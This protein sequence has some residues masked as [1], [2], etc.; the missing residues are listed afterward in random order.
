MKKILITLLA[1]TAILFNSCET[2]F[3]VTAEW[4]DI[5]VV[6]GLIS[7]NDTIHYIKVNKAFLGQGNALA[8]AQEADSSSYLGQIDVWLVEKSNNQELRRFKLDTTVVY[9]KEPG[10]FYAPE[11]VVYKTGFRVPTDYI[12]K[13]ITYHLEINNLITGKVVSSVTPLVHDFNIET[14]RPGLQAINFTAESNQRVKWS[15][16]VNGRRY[17]VTI[18]FWFDEVHAPARD[19]ITR[20]VDWDFSTV[21]SSSVKGGEPMELLYMPSGFFNMCHTLIPYKQGS[22]FS[23]DQVLARLVNRVEFLFAV[24]G[25]EFNT[26]MEVNEPSGSIVQDK[27]TYTNIVNGIGLFSCRFVKSSETPNAKMRVGPSTEEKLINEGL[28]FVK[29]IGN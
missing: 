20:Y 12:A 6:Y 29:K 28:K 21:K 19:T 22:S 24:A 11:Q 3:D 27:P 7:Q 13:K 5:T 8:Y 16:A 17:D 9:N 14:P 25:D 2:D 15:S 23:E 26:Y 10:I 4:K 18:R 1:L